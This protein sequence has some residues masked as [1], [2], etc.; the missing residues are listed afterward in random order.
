MK[1]LI[2]ILFW[3]SSVSLVGQQLH[4]KSDEVKVKFHYVSK[5]AEG[6]LGDFQADIYWDPE[7]LSKS[8]ISGSVATKTIDTGIGLRDRHLKSGSYF[9]ADEHPK[10]TFKSNTIKKT[11]TGYRV[12]GDLTIAGITDDMTI[13]FT[14]DGSRFK[15]TS[16]IYSNDYEIMTNKDREKSRVDIEFLVPVK[17]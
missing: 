7:N 14:F 12:S 11:D 10:M 1:Y 3:F 2:I 6:T 5:G 16:T 8:S 13:D 9:D 17:N 4:V 15:G